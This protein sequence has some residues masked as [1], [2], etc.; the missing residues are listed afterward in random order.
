VF[1]VQLLEDLHRTG[2]R[3]DA[4]GNHRQ[5]LKDERVMA[6]SVLGHVLGSV[7]LVER[8]GLAG[9]IR[10]TESEGCS[11]SEYRS[12]TRAIRIAQD[13]DLRQRKK[14]DK[15]NW[16]SWIQQRRERG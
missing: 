13:G 15:S 4:H 3:Y 10:H 9:R 6:M 2:K 16:P 5:L 8:V 1:T 12:C 11:G 14:A 7:R